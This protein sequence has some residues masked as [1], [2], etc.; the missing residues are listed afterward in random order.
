MEY[1]SG[2][3]WI[4]NSALRID[5]NTES[6]AGCMPKN[7]LRLKGYS[8]L[9]FTTVLADFLGQAFLL[10][11]CVKWLSKFVL[12]DSSH[13][14]WSA[15]I[16]GGHLVWFWQS[17]LSVYLL[18]LSSTGVPKCYL[19]N[20]CQSAWRGRSGGMGIKNMGRGPTGSWRIRGIV[21]AYLT[22][23]L[24]SEWEVFVCGKGIQQGASDQLA[25]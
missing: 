10:V 24:A 19:E 15:G 20:L 23:C 12:K 4:L 21:G 22:S 16:S 13:S 5:W 9:V 6:H 2:G 3:K 11:L 25:F 8:S 7:D 18:Y 1:A 17:S 14:E